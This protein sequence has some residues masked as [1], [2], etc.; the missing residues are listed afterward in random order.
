MEL[1]C[2]NRCEMIGGTELALQHEEETG[3]AVRRLTEAEARGVREI[4]AEEGRG[5]DGRPVSAML[6]TLLT[7]TGRQLARSIAGRFGGG[8]GLD[9]PGI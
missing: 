3:H 4:W 8:G 5:A 6:A 1:W 7:E 2:C 9:D